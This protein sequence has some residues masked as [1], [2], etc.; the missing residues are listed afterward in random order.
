MQKKHRHIGVSLRIGLLSLYTTVFASCAHTRQALSS[1][2]ILG[3]MQSVY[4][5]NNPIKY[6]RLLGVVGGMLCCGAVSYYLYY[7]S[8]N[9]PIPM[10]PTSGSSG[11]NASMP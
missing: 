9:L 2:W 10:L 4:T 8:N 1:G 6:W 7:P 5:I 3:D 11:W